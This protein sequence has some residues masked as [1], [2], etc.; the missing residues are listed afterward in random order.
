MQAV[1]TPNSPLEVRTREA[2]VHYGDDTKLTKHTLASDTPANS[3]KRERWR[4]WAVDSASYD[5]THHTRESHR[6][7][8][9]HTNSHC[10]ILEEGGAR[11]SQLA[12]RLKQFHFRRVS[13]TRLEFHYRVH[14]RVFS[15]F[16][17][18]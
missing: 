7:Y 11:T 3:R 9:G 18:F 8:I 12:L 2:G 13:V 4:R 10:T 1:N 17:N 16:K 14:T 15:T 5:K 6:E